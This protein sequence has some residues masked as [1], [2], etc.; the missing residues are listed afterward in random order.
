MFKISILPEEIEK[1]P[2]GSFPGKIYVVDKTG[3]DFLKA[4]AYLRAQKIIGFDTET[5]P[6]FSPGQQHN[7]VALLQL[8]GPRK[9]FLF[10]VGKMGMPKAL[11]RLMANPHVLK[12]GA[13]VHDDV[14]GI[15]YY[16]KFDARGFV[17]LQRIAFEW[18]IR[19]KSVK[20]LGAN[21]LGIRISKSQQL[22]NWE[23]EELSAGQQMYAAT[24][25]WVCRE[26][27]LKLLKSEK[28][29]LTPE[30][31]NPPQPQQAPKVQQAAPA[32]PKAEDGK[33]TAR[34]R[35]RRRHR[36]PKT[37]QQEAQPENNG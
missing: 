1:M 26:M 9:A 28:H 33:A 13:A 24:D 21:I 4:I 30:Q 35:H 14:R 29:P 31:L 16:Q 19:D 36:K 32:A 10:R 20:K 37:A 5:R 3:L 17:D 7:H 12:V 8:S 25:A 6:V 23:A 22:S 27:Y 18:G 34:K 2:L 15:Q 11:C